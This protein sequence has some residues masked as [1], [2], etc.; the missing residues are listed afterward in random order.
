[1][2][3]KTQVDRYQEPVT[4]RLD[5]WKRL[6]EEEQTR[7]FAQEYLRCLDAEFLTAFDYAEIIESAGRMYLDQS[8]PSR[9]HKRSW[10]IFPWQVALKP[11]TEWARP[12]RLAARRA[13]AIQERG[14]V[15][16]LFYFVYN[17]FFSL[18]R[19]LLKV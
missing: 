3:D 12:E 6:F 4:D 8:K 18:I 7:H 19:N 2:G 1:M 17:N 16:G 14:L 5:Q 10:A 15:R 13:L 11:W 9:P